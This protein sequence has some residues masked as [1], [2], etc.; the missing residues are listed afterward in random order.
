MPNCNHHVS[1]LIEGPL[2][3]KVKVLQTFI[4][5]ALMMSNLL[6]WRNKVTEG[7]NNKPI[8]IPNS[9]CN[10]DNQNNHLITIQIKILINSIEMSSHL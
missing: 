7:Q 2:Q 8:D 1:Q 9:Y 3:T 4:T 5:T 6:L 10:F